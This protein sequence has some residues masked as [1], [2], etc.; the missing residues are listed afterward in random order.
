MLILDPRNGLA[1]D[2]ILAALS[3]LGHGKLVKSFGAEILEAAGAEGRIIVKK[4]KDGKRVDVE[5]EKDIKGFEEAYGRCMGLE[6]DLK[7]KTFAKKTI[8]KIIDAEKKHHAGH[9]HLH[10][11]GSADTLVD[12]FTAG[13]VFLEYGFDA[14]CMPIGIGSGKIKIAHGLVDNPPPASRIMLEGYE[15]IRHGIEA[16][17]STPTGIAIATNFMQVKNLEGFRVKRTGK[18]YGSMELKGHENRLEVHEVE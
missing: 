2:M 7:V 5:I 4:H 11:L 15:T 14:R 12:V 17:L 3:D 18:G 10:E 8:D 9:A 13:R 16:E 6:M 1:G